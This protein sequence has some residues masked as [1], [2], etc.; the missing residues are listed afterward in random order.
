MVNDSS[1]LCSSV[2]ISGRKVVVTNS[3]FCVLIISAFPCLS[4]FLPWIFH[5]TFG[6]LGVQMN[7]SFAYLALYMVTGF[8]YKRQYRM[9]RFHMVSLGFISPSSPC[10]SY[11]EQCDDIVKLTE[12]LEFITCLGCRQVTVIQ[13]RQPCPKDLL[14]LSWHRFVL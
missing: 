6:I 10:S 11:W 8:L 14:C 4:I 12:F 1:I 3:W 9:L 13:Y 2:N 7:Q 5:N